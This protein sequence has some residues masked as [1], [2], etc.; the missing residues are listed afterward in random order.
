MVSLLRY[1]A[2]NNFMAV[3]LIAHDI[4]PLIDA[5]HSSNELAYRRFDLL[6]ASSSSPQEPQ[7]VSAPIS[8]ALIRRLFARPER[9]AQSQF[10]R[11][12]IAGRMFERLSLIKINPDQILDAGCGEGDDLLTLRQHF[13][14]STLLG[15]DAALPML[16]ETRQREARSWSGMQRLMRVLRVRSQ[17]LSA[18]SALVCADFGRLPL[19]AAAMDM[20]WSNLALHWHPQPHRV[21]AEWAR[22]L[23]VDGL[24]MFCCF[25]PDTFKELREVAAV[26]GTHARVLPFV[27]L[28]DYGDMLVDAGFSSPVMDMEKLNITYSSVEKLLADVR[29]FGGNP[30]QDRSRGLMSR[31]QGQSLSRAL[32]QR[33]DRDGRLRLTIEV[34]YGHAFRAR[35]RTTGTGEP[36]VHFDRRKI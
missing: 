21:L 6:M 28:H 7:R 27:D 32:E 5:L 19:K 15:L 4:C 34:I 33:V 36:I 14:R 10:L 22:V 25:G 26:T 8:L 3:A 12:E 35:P 9:V 20:V 31:Q 30:L 23:R 24:L 13:P 1:T 16:S 2:P 17:H 11:R 18:Q 29:A